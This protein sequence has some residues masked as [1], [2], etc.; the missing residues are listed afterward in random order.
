MMTNEEV[1]AITGDALSKLGEHFDSVQICAT[2]CEGAV[3]TI[4]FRGTGNFYARKASC[5]SFAQMDVHRD[6]AEELARVIKE[7]E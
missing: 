5:E 7:K 1:T 6:A 4:H 3:T 2:Q